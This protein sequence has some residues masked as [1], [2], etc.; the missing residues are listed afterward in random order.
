[1][2]VQDRGVE[3]GAGTPQA[4]GSRPLPLR[5]ARRAIEPH[6]GPFAFFLFIWPLTGP[7]ER[8][9]TGQGRHKLRV[10]QPQYHSIVCLVVLARA[11]VAADVPST[12]AVEC[13]QPVLIERTH[14]SYQF[15]DL[16]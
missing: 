6:G 3:L 4:Q 1:M 14:V 15:A 7:G 11:F 12:D 8:G 16:V 13:R 10:E 5:V 2:K 9:S